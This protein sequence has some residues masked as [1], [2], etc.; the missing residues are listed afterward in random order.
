MLGSKW[1]LND[2]DVLHRLNL[3]FMANVNTAYDASVKVVLTL[4]FEF[5]VH[6]DLHSSTTKV[7]S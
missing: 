3:S 5:L 6:I 4:K 7:E 2:I 1:P